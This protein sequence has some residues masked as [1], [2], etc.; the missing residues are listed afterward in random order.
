MLLNGGLQE[1]GVVMHM[2]RTFVVWGLL[3]V[4]LLYGVVECPAQDD[5]DTLRDYI[6]EKATNQID[7]ELGTEINLVLSEGDGFRLECSENDYGLEDVLVYLGPSP[8]GGRKR[9][10][11]YGVFADGRIWGGTS[12]P[13]SGSSYWQSGSAPVAMGVQQRR[14]EDGTLKVWMGAVG[15]AENV[16]SLYEITHPPLGTHDRALGLVKFWSEAKY[17][18]AFFDQV[19]DLDWDK[20]LEEYLPRVMD[21]KSD[22]EYAELVMKCCALLKDGHTSVYISHYHSALS[23]PIEVQPLQG[24]AIVVAVGKR[25]DIDKARLGPGDEIT[26]VDDRPVQE[27][28]EQDIYPYTMAGSPQGR[29]NQAYPRLLE[30][31]MESQVTLRIR[32]LDGTEDDVKIARDPRC[33]TDWRPASRPPFEYKELRGKIAYVYLGSFADRKTVIQFDEVFDDIRKAQGLIID[34]RDNGGGSSDI[35]YDVIGRL[36]DRTL[37]TSRWKTRK[38]MPAF[39]A[40]GEEEEWYEGTHD[41]VQ[42]RGDDP[43]LGPV[44]VLTNVGTVSAAEDF[45]VPLHASGRATLVGGRTAG[46]TGQPLIIKFP[47]GAAAICTKWDSYPDGREFVGVGVIPDVEIYP[48]PQD[49]ASGRDAVLEK[50]IEVLKELIGKGVSH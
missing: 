47:G 15:G 39:R 50:G 26:H 25:D 16:R 28:L 45:L 10:W 30:G 8:E 33:E 43:F 23:P 31:P 4:A 2:R 1:R 5:R 38:Y 46:T 41:P 49:I 9:L 7:Y 14:Q 44:V 40:W 29:D 34:V 35:G 24:K 3:V 27:V 19:P 18:F 17:N 42:P 32:R 11:I 12:G 13:G 37:E 36:T 21:A 22:D 48:T 20:V 6:R